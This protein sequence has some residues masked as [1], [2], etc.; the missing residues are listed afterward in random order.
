M[1]GSLGIIQYILL[2]WVS[3][4]FKECLLFFDFTIK[5]S[6]LDTTV[7][8]DAW[9]LKELTSHCSTV[10]VTMCAYGTPYKKPTTVSFWLHGKSSI[11]A[12][13][14]IF[15]NKKCRPVRLGKGKPTL[16]SFG[17]CEHLSLTGLS[18]NK[19]FNTK[20][21]EAYPFGLAEDLVA[22]LTGWWCGLCQQHGYGLCKGNPT[23]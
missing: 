11:D 12:L 14:A 22:A 7:A 19:T 3:Y 2:F 4:V 20:D 15:G 16:C 6:Y 8:T 5:W 13:P 18:A 23:T 1:F 21:A 9:H 17:Q 10:A